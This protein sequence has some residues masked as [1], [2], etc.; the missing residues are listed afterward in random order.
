MFRTVGTLFVLLAIGTV[1]MAWSH[2]PPP[3]KPAS[4]TIDPYQIQLR[5]GPLPAQEFNDRSL[6]F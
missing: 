6:T 4:R 2:G 3:S 1:A 5:A